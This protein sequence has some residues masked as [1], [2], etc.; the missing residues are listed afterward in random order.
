MPGDADVHGC[1]QCGA[2]FDAPPPSG[3]CSRCGEPW[4]VALGGSPSAEKAQALIAWARRDATRAVEARGAML[5]AIVGLL[6]GLGVSVALPQYNDLRIPIVMYGGI[7]GA[8]VGTYSALPINARL[9]PQSRL[10]PVVLRGERRYL[11]VAMCVWGLLPLAV[12]GVLVAFSSGGRSEHVVRGLVGS[13]WAAIT[14]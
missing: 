3:Q 14:P 7:L 12:I 9:R 6:L 2:F 4:V 11:A 10:Q 1:A 5:G 13:I 8:L